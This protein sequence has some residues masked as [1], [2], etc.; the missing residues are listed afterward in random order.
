MI[1]IHLSDTH[2]GTEMRPVQTA[3]LDFL[4]QSPPDLIL[5]T[6]DIT[7]RATSAQFAAAA[8]FIQQL[9]QCPLLA[10]P[11]NHDISSHNLWERFMQPYA[12]FNTVFGSELEPCFENEQLLLV[13]VNSTRRYRQKDGEISAQQIVAVETR[14]MATE[15]GKLKILATHHPFDVVLRRDNKNRIHNAHQALQRWASAGLDLVMGGHIHYPF[16]APLQSRYKTLSRPVWI[17][18]AGTAIS[19]RI[20]DGKPNSFNR[21]VIGVEMSETRLER[22]DYL[23]KRGFC[24]AAVETPWS[25]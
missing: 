6:G 10:V 11:G 23:E 14:L 18:Q 16:F 3:L 21:L 2:F 24:K 19:R 25:H 12:A 15:P 9:P 20:R 7:Q 17:A 22:W 5:L 8:H 4:H 13:C 1:L